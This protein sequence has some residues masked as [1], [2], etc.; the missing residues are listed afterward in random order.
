MRYPEHAWRHEMEECR[1][2]RV[3]RFASMAGLEGLADLMNMRDARVD[4][5]K[6]QLDEDP[7]QFRSA[8]TGCHLYDM[9]LVREDR[10]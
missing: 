4:Y 7:M 1:G 8:H 6:L 5:Q 10:R 9:T 3:H 2:R